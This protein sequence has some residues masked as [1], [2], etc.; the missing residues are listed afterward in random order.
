[1]TRQEKWKLEWV[2]EDQKKGIFYLKKE[3]VGR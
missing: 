3:V 2:N 1:M